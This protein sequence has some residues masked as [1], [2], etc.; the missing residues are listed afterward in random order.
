[1][2]ETSLSSKK[3]LKVIS[4]KNKLPLLIEQ[5]K[6]PHITGVITVSASGKYFKPVII[7]PNKK[8]NK[9]SR[10]I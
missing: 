2:D 8:K 5:P 7:L 3:R 10:R 4:Q 6:I 9:Y 1:M